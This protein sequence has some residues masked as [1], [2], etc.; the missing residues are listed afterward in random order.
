VSG[1]SYPPDRSRSA[2]LVVA[3]DAATGEL[4]WSSR[5]DGPAGC[6]DYA[7]DYANAVAAGTGAVYVTGASEAPGTRLDVATVSYDAATG[8]ELCVARYDGPAGGGD[9]GR[10]VALGPDGSIYVAGETTSRRGYHD[11]VTIRYRGS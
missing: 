3:Y 2:A 11:Y 1:H 7:N 9:L 8:E 4:R 5:Y 6:N 10:A